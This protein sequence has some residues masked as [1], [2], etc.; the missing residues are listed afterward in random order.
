MGLVPSALALLHSVNVCSFFFFFL[1]NFTNLSSQFFSCYV[2][3]PSFSFLYFLFNLLI[4]FPCQILQTLTTALVLVSSPFS[5]ESNPPNPLQKTLNSPAVTI[6]PTLT[7]PPLF[8][9]SLSK[10]KL[11]LEDSGRCRGAGACEN[12]EPW[13]V[14]NL[15]GFSFTFLEFSWR[16]GISAERKQD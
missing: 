13:Q 10:I 14:L 8:P 9:E 15:E 2:C 5:L 3:Q 11:T 4:S 1:E 16:T 6:K 12:R 7:H